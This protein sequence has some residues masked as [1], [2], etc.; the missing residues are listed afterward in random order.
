MGGITMEREQRILWAFVAMLAICVSISVSLPARWESGHAPRVTV[1]LHNLST[2]TTIQIR[3]RARREVLRGEFRQL[4]S[5]T[6]D[7]LK[8]G[9]LLS[10]HGSAIGSAEVELTRYGNGVLVQE[11]EIDVDGLTANAAF[12]VLVDG[13]TVATFVTDADGAAEMDRFGRVPDTLARSGD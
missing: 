2:S 11:F 1:A 6:S 7:L 4:A 12:D 13:R 9:H 5:T 10:S 3:D 8:V